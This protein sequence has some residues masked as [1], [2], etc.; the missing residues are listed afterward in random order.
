[1]INAAETDY[2]WPQVMHVFWHKHGGGGG[3]MEDAAAVSEKRTLFNAEREH[4]TVEMM[5]GSRYSLQRKI[6]CRS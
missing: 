5:S 4:R 1:V 2:D 3:G 6:Q